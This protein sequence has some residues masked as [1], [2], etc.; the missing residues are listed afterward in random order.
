MLYSNKR[1]QFPAVCCTSAR[2]SLQHYCHF[3]SIPRQASTP[4]S[5]VPLHNHNHNHNYDQPTHPLQKNK[6][7]AFLPPKINYRHQR[8]ARGSH[9]VKIDP[10]SHPPRSRFATQ[11]NNSNLSSILP[12][13][14]KPHRRSPSRVRISTYHC[15]STTTIITLEP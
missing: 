14:P 2:L 13:N 15:R 3:R 8:I 11:P 4:K 12:I 7:M 9:G 6:R 5:L 1:N 10:V